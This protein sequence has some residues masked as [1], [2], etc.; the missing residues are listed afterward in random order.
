[1][2][3]LD[4][5]ATETGSIQ[6]KDEE[7]MYL[8]QLNLSTGLSCWEYA[9]IS[10]K[11]SYV[12]EIFFFINKMF[13]TEPNSQCNDAI[14][15]VI[16]N[17]RNIEKLLHCAIFAKSCDKHNFIDGFS[18]LIV[19]FHSILCDWLSNSGLIK[20]LGSAVICKNSRLTHFL[21][22]YCDEINEEIF[23]RINLFQNAT[24]IFGL[25][26]TA[27]ESKEE[28]CV[29]SLLTACLSEIETFRQ[30]TDIWND[31]HQVASVVFLQAIREGWAAV[32]EL[33]LTH[34]FNFEGNAHLPNPYVNA[35]TVAAAH[36]QVALF[37]MLM[38]Y[39]RQCGLDVSESFWCIILKE[40]VVQNILLV[41]VANYEN[42]FSPINENV[43]R[44][45][46]R[47]AATCDNVFM[48]KKCL[49]YGF[50]I[51]ELDN[52]TK[53]TILHY[54]AHSGGKLV[55]SHI[56]HKL[57]GS[58]LVD[59][60][61]QKE[62]TALQIACRCFNVDAVSLLVEES[63][64]DIVDQDGRTVLH[65]CAALCTNGDRDKTNR[66]E[67]MLQTL[68][69][70][71]LAQ[72][73]H[74]NQHDKSNYTAIDILIN[75]K[76]VQA[77]RYFNNDNI[78]LSSVDRALAQYPENANVMV[79]LLH[80]SSIRQH[81]S[82]NKLRMRTNNPEVKVKPFYSPS[83]F[84]T[85]AFHIFAVHH[86][87]ENVKMII[88]ARANIL[89]T[90]KLGDTVLHT[91]VRQSVVNK[92]REQE[93]VRMA[94]I[95]FYD[96]Y[97]A[98][99]ISNCNCVGISGR[100]DV[101]DA[102]KYKNF[103]DTFRVTFLMLTRA[104]V[105]KQGLT[106]LNLAVKEG[107]TLFLQWLLK[108]KG[109]ITH[110]KTCENNENNFTLQRIKKFDITS[111]CPETMVCVENLEFLLK[112]L[113]EHCLFITTATHCNSEIHCA[114]ANSNKI[115]GGT[116]T[117][118]IKESQMSLFEA[119]AN[120]PLNEKQTARLL[121]MQPLS[122][123]VE[124]YWPAYRKLSIAIFIFHVLYM[125]FHT[126]ISQWSVENYLTHST[127][128]KQMNNINRQGQ[129]HQNATAS[130]SGCS[131]GFN[132]WSIFLYI[133]A[134]YPLICLVIVVYCVSTLWY[135]IR[136]FAL[137]Q[138]K[139]LLKVFTKQFKYQKKLR[140]IH[141]KSD[142][143]SVMV[144][145]RLID[146]ESTTKLVEVKKPHFFRANK[147]RWSVFLWPIFSVLYTLLFFSTN[148]AWCILH[149]TCSKDRPYVLAA[150]L[151]I[152]WM[153]T[154]FHLKGIKKHHILIRVIYT[155][156]KDDF[157]PFALIFAF[158]IVGFTVAIHVVLSFPPSV[159]KVANNTLYEPLFFGPILVPNLGDF[160]DHNEI[161]V[162]DVS[163]IRFAIY[164]YL[165]VV[166]IVSLVLMNVLIA[167][168]NSSY[169]SVLEKEEAIWHVQSLRHAIIMKY[170]FST[171]FAFFNIPRHSTKPKTYI[172]TD[173][174]GEISKIKLTYY[175]CDKHND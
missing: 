1:M 75:R 135:N 72:F 34:H 40:S 38:R 170:A 96:Y 9:A 127:T 51:F 77:I 73:N 2:E 149:Y 57:N 93:Y 165:F 67:L 132:P 104:V 28:K 47:I 88:E 87:L 146:E 58:V 160:F 41:A 92:Q 64:L 152:G 115:N 53:N 153:I 172:F 20:L 156:I 128:R 131:I 71:F 119:I 144:S 29:L 49:H 61:N 109:D 175:R 33:F 138:E 55:I 43:V 76:H 32:V 106:V 79:A 169:T 116:R 45:V 148:L 62:E 4:Y 111:L 174:S 108:T 89:A 102:Q 113:Q 158:F 97:M 126:G 36:K 54:A 48:V 166:L 85:T 154:P 129:T 5:C 65:I 159:V 124:N 84:K 140:R 30:L 168:F 3:L 145:S 123:L 25:L 94:S 78:L 107:A 133:S 121:D 173:C 120:L 52:V 139:V 91:L 122:Y 110:S 171:L 98:S 44:M 155:I 134:I 163:R 150:F 100:Y 16:N 151:M 103:K 12:S 11:Y 10:G 46:V 15:H 167:K 147:L 26:I 142:D 105:N 86:D 130:I 80:N 83:V 39:L 90:D 60:R 59:I 22:N 112:K 19:R 81:L 56:L 136:N 7:E 157:F 66:K 101:E 42:I 114:L 164:C 74:V 17:N 14:I 82:Q 143:D 125:A 21:V 99:V 63:N 35:L 117:I 13:Q 162:H 69:F 68:R 141:S 37:E 27:S 31:F 18:S 8:R 95:L 70:R 137:L 161:Q 23:F 118:E 50:D 24:K 6:H